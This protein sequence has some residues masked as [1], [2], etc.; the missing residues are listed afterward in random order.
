MGLAAATYADRW[1]LRSGRPRQL[2]AAHPELGAALLVAAAWG[3]LLVRAQPGVAGGGSMPGMTSGAGHSALSLVS[4]GLAYWLVMCVAMMGPVALAG[5]RH[6][7]L[8][9]LRW[10]CRRA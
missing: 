10:R 1:Q 8:N 5:V 6:P 4:G 3:F 7:G 2:M 9:S